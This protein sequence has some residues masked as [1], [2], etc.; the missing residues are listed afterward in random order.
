MDETS[1]ETRLPGDP[2]DTRTRLDDDSTQATP[3][4]PPSI[5]QYRVLGKLGEGGMGVVSIELSRF[6]HASLSNSTV[7]G[8]VFCEAG[9]AVCDAQSAAMTVGCASAPEDCRS[10]VPSSATGPAARREGVEPPSLPFNRGLGPHERAFGSEL[11]AYP[12]VRLP[13]RPGPAEVESGPA[14]RRP[15]R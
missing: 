3:E 1:D 13:Q 15:A 7:T 8:A 2:E 14:L 6:S 12:G 10:P 11:F 5:G 9:D 4:L